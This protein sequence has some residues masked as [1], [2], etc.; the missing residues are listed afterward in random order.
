M[1]ECILLAGQLMI[2]ATHDISNGVNVSPSGVD[3]EIFVPV[4]GTSFTNTVG[5]TDGGTVAMNMTT[6]RATYQ[7]YIYQSEYG[8]FTIQGLLES[9]PTGGN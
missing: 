1:I 9:C 6:Y 8:E 4:V 2:H 7:V 5:M 3:Y